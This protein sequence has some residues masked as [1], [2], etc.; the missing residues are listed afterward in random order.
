MPEATLST[1]PNTPTTIDDDSNSFPDR[2]NIRL[3]SEDLRVRRIRLTAKEDPNFQKLIPKLKPQPQNWPLAT[4]QDLRNLVSRFLQASQNAAE[5]SSTLD[6]FVDEFRTWQ[7]TQGMS[8]ISNGEFNATRASCR[9]GI[10]VEIRRLIIPSIIN[11]CHIPKIFTFG[12]EKEWKID[13]NY[14]LPSTGREDVIAP[15]KP[16]IAI[17]FPFDAFDAPSNRGWPSPYPTDLDYCLSPNEENGGCFPFF[18]CEA[19]DGTPNEEAACH[20]NLYSASQALYNIFQWMDRAGQRD[21]FLQRVRVFSMV[22]ARSTIDVRVHRADVQHGQL[23]FSFDEVFS[24]NNY[25]K[26]DAYQVYRNILEIYGKG[27]LLKILQAAFQK[28]SAKER[29]LVQREG[30]DEGT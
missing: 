29:L 17:S 2:F 6:Q 9:P 24:C 28:V 10:K 3:S 25:T 5:F 8:P 12:L 18:F 14:R 19:G 1:L 26:D 11:I 23:C 22:I 20:A 7:H 30:G 21:V 16:D 27:V 4:Q 13:K 15:P